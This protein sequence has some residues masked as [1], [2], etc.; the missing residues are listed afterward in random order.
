MASDTYMP[1]LRE[2]TKT[3][4]TPGNNL[5]M[6]IYEN[7]L[8]KRDYLTISFYEGVQ[9]KRREEKLYPKMINDKRLLFS[10]KPFDK[11]IWCDN[12][13]EIDFNDQQDIQSRLYHVIKFTGS[14]IYL[15]KSFVANIKADYDNKPIKIKCSFNTLSAIKIKLNILGK[16]I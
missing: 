1:L 6:A 7:E 5:L 14:S 11:F 8:G 9:K 3:Y 16:I 13:E 12:P 10:I 4:A 15:G 2:D